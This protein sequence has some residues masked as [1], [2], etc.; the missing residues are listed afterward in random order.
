MRSGVMRAWAQQLVSAPPPQFGEVFVPGGGLL[1]QADSV[2]E[3]A[4]PQVGRQLP[5]LRAR[6]EI[7]TRFSLCGKGRF[8]GIGIA[9][10]PGP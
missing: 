2:V 8:Q 1:R 10:I 4:P 3:V 5:Q 7:G 9:R 6:P